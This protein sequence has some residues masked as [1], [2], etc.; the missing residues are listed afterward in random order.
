[1]ELELS[2]P[3]TLGDAIRQ[4]RSHAGL[5]QEALASKAGLAVKTLRLVESGSSDPRDGTV[6]AIC[7]GLDI[8][9]IILRCMTA[10]E[11][12]RI[13]IA[14]MLDAYHKHKQD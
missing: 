13:K 11:D 4:V 9:P 10:S 7:T 12:S 6:D 2:K 8:P 1:M 14:A 5:S 3:L